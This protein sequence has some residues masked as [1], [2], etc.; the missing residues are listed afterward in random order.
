M[1]TPKQIEKAADKIIPIWDDLKEW[2][3]LDLIDRITMRLGQD[4]EDI[5]FSSSEKYRIS[6]FEEL[7]GLVTELQKRIAR[8]VNISEQQLKQV[9]LDYAE[10][11]AGQDAQALNTGEETLETSEN[12][13]TDTLH[14]E[15]QNTAQNEPQTKT[16]VSNA[17]SDRMKDIAND[18]YLRTNGELRNFTG[19]TADSVQTEFIKELDKAYLK[20]ASNTCSQW[21][22]AREAIDNIIKY[23][24]RVTYPSGHTDTIEVAVI[25]AIRTGIARMSAELTLQSAEENG[26]DYVA[27]S[28]HLGA[29]TG[30][31]GENAGNHAWWQ[32]KVYKING[33]D[34]YPNLGETTG[35]PHDPHGLCGYNCRHSIALFDPEVMRNPF[36]QYDEEENKEY[37]ENTQKQRKYEREIRKAKT[38]VNALARALETATDPKL[39][40]SLQTSLDEAKAKRDNLLDEY[41]TFCNEHGFRVSY[42]RMDVARKVEKNEDYSDFGRSIKNLFDKN[43][44]SVVNDFTKHL[45][46]MKNKNVSILLQKAHGQVNYEQSARKNS[47]FNAKVN[48]V[49]L[50]R[51]ASTSTVAHEL[52]HKIDS[53]NKISANGFLNNAIRNDYNELQKKAID[54][55]QTLENMLYSKY[56]E[57]FV[58]K[59]KMKEEYRGISDI[60]HGMSNKNIDFGYGHYKNNY[61]EKPFKLQKEIFAQYGRMYFEENKDVLKM[62]QDIFPEITS[63]VNAII[64]VTIQFGK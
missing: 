47:Y 18:A 21:Q 28:G 25:R 52:F 30:D 31:G 22:A 8:T 15:P 13:N 24:G 40:E 33:S 20:V 3:V 43:Y 6:V 7:G 26:I 14:P 38:E 41:R 9:F 59:G 48:T 46:D 10:T 27:V 35:Y 29:R 42:E 16:V 5:T 60:I 4:D 23:Q 55:G 50:A 54:S 1:L 17:M 58:K 62:L 32:S 12:T 37:Y 53:D 49:F 51:G 44:Q 11:A 39:K 64:S 34:K 36:K 45:S 63:Q 61:W 19:T 56:P 57:A 2:I